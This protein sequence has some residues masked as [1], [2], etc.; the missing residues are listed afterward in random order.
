[1][2]DG[3]SLPRGVGVTKIVPGSG[4]S[5]LGGS[6]LFWVVLSVC[7]SAMATAYNVVVVELV[8]L[9]PASAET[10]FDSAFEKS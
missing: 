10:N 7:V 9:P 6:E 4:I 3:P 5:K 8:L 2:A 1:M